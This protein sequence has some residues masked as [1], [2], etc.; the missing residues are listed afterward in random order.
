MSKF[1]DKLKNISQAATQPMGFGRRQVAET[2]PGLLLV[3]RL[4][5]GS[6]G[7]L[8]GSVAGADAG[9][10]DVSASEGDDKTLQKC[11]R[12]AP[13]IP[14][15]GWL[16]G[17][18]RPGGGELACPDCD[19]VILPARMPV[20]TLEDSTEVGRILEVSASLNA[21]IL[22]TVNDLPV[23]GV[24]ITF[25]GEDGLS[26]TWQRLMTL[27]H[28]ADLLVKPLLTVVPPGIGAGGIK[29]LWEAGVDGVIVET[30]AG[31]SGGQL[32]RLREA[33]SQL[34]PPSSGRRGKVKALLPKTGQEAALTTEEELP[35]DLR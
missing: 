31:K 8:A 18:G 9:L 3:A 19:F 11:A 13:D 34:G 32:K 23:D 2:S 26:L 29:L 16:K 4:A 15:G 28:L 7:K 10:V 33:I 12:A 5:G 17:E 21:G 25:E 24:L 20:G 22:R 27:Q 14:W 1:A 35:G 30:E 6:G